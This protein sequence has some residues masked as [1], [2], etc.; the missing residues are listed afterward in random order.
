[1]AG[2]SCTLGTS[3]LQKSNIFEYCILYQCPF[4]FFFR[5][6]PA[7][8]GGSQTRGRIGATAPGLCHSHNSAGSELHLLPTPQ[9]MAVLDP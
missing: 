9:L 5:A 2:L 7:V 4:F 1:M 3:D 8:Y 6:A